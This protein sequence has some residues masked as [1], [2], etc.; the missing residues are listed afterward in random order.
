MKGFF[1]AA[2]AV[3][4]L[5]ACG[6]GGGSTGGPVTPSTPTPV[7][8]YSVALHWAPASSVGITALFRRAAVVR[9]FDTSSGTT[10][11]AQSGNGGSGVYDPSSGPA[12]VT[13]SVSPMPSPLTATFTTT[14]TLAVVTP[15]PAPA[16]PNPSASPAAL[17]VPTQSNTAQS[18]ATVTVTSNGASA[19]DN[20]LL[21][22]SLTL[23]IS[24]GGHNLSSSD[25]PAYTFDS[26]CNAVGQASTTGADLYLTGPLSGT[27]EPENTL[28][29]PNGGIAEMHG[30]D[31]STL[32]AA[33]WQNAGTAIGLNTY[34]VT[35]L[36][37]TIILKA[38]NGKIV[39]LG[40]GQEV[41]PG[42]G[43]SDAVLE[44]GYACLN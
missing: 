7:V 31:I 20:F 39:V 18:G 12:Y 14:S 34:A 28:H 22:K 27:S 33:S 21:I 11:I 43:S 40:A 13:A 32:T 15:T 4:V 16:S 25:F 2:I 42:N 29:Y 36:D 1:L 23:A 35:N 37:D 10:I 17:I 9:R 24:S 38:G 5:A 19:T 8:K 26:N 30:Y 6:G 41:I 3:T 44:T